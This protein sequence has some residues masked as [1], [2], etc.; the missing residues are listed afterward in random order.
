MSDYYIYYIHGY[1]SEPNS[2]KGC[3]FKKKLN[4]E[5]IKYRDCEPKD[6]II[7]DCLRMIDNSIRTNKKIVLVGSSLGGYLAARTALDNPNIKKTILLNPA[8]IPPYFD[9]E[10]IKDMPKRILSEMKDNRLFKEKIKSDILILLGTDDEVVS[11]NWGITFAK[12]QLATVR[13]LKDDHSFSNNLE[14][15]PKIIIEYLNKSIN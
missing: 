3:L 15:L 9:I 8:I 1:L 2:T 14:Q 5:A 6:L 4:A 7:S 11:N 10:Q 13:F 12:R